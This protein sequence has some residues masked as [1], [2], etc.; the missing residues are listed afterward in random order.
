[1]V[2]LDGCMTLIKGNIKII[3]IIVIVPCNIELP[4]AADLKREGAC[5]DG[6]PVARVPLSRPLVGRDD[7]SSVGAPRQMRVHVA[8]L[9][10]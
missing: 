3:A 7:P 10:E 1:L 5:C 9:G 6:D 4:T 8:A 2:D